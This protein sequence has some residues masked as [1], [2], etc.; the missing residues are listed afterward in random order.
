MFGRIFD[1]IRLPSFILTSIA[2]LWLGLFFE[3]PF[4]V[5]PL[6]GSLFILYMERGLMLKNVVGGHLIGLVCAFIHPIVHFYLDLSFLPASVVAAVTIAVAL[7]A[8]TL[9][10]SLSGLKHEPAIATVL[11]FFEIGERSTNLLFG[12]VPWKDVILFLI[13]LV[14]VT[15]IVWIYVRNR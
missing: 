4:M 11:L 12:L 5:P 9:I 1:I 8:A 6:V 14:I 10:M 3:V 13:G 7:A 2:I 15:I